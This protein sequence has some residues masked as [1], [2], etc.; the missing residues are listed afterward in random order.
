MGWRGKGGEVVEMNCLCGNYKRE[1]P[2]S[3][4]QVSARTG[5]HRQR[6]ED[7]LRLV[8][9]CIPYRWRKEKTGQKGDTEDII[10]VLMVSSPKRD[11]LVFPKGGWEDDETV[12][13]A[14]CREVLEEAGV[15]GILRETPLGMWE[16]R[17]KSSQNLCCLEGGCRGY[18]FALEVTEE[19][20]TWPEQKNRN[21]KWLN[22]RE[23][24]RLCRYEWMCQALEEFLRVMAEERNLKTGE[25]VNP[26]SNSK[27]K[28]V[29][30]IIDLAQIGCTWH[31]MNSFTSSSP[32]KAKKKQ[33]ATTSAKTQEQQH[34][35]AWGGRYLG[36]RRRP[37]G[38]YA[39]EIRDPSTKER[40]WLGTFDTAEEAALAYDRAARSMR[41]SRARTNFVYS[42]TPPGSSVTP[43]ISPDEETQH[44]H[45]DFSSLFTANS[46]A[47]QQPDPS[48]RP[49]EFNISG[50]F[51]GITDN[52]AWAASSG[53]YSQSQPF[54]APTVD[55]PN[56][57]QLYDDN[58][59]ELPPLP[60]DITSSTGYYE[61]GF[62]Y[63]EQSTGMGFESSSW[64]SYSYMGLDS[65][66]YVHSPLLSTMPAVSEKVPEGFDFGSSSY[67]F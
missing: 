44:N 60:P 19:L 50:G 30:L 14:A 34:G 56:F 17:S 36:V 18:M 25:Q 6:Y 10:E 7:K 24:F 52:D 41:G 48:D 27:G 35:T 53:I 2:M 54:Q 4:L 26:S 16:F 21:R 15:K 22:I 46:V 65:G 66:E 39:A 43:I 23:A 31:L 3:S 20:D 33:T 38:R 5:R 12:M 49:T 62:G 67:L 37:W 28:T 45:H 9:G 42:D 61:N 55:V 29:E 13:E 64:P 51:L 58:N 59:T 57:H 63:S 1:P 32:S 11:D 8:S 47:H 40:H